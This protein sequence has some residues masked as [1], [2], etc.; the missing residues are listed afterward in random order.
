MRIIAIVTM[1][2]KMTSWPSATWM[3]RSVRPSST[4]HGM[5]AE[6]TMTAAATSATRSRTA[7]LI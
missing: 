4:A 5:K 7:A 3:P 2:V 1:A 6:K